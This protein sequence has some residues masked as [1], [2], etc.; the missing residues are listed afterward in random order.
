MSATLVFTYWDACASP[1]GNIALLSLSI[2]ITVGGNC[3]GVS[4]PVSKQMIL[5]KSISKNKFSVQ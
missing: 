3:R 5:L 2:S 1:K 4:E